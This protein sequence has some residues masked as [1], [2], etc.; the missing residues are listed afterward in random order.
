MS[1]VSGST[2]GLRAIKSQ[3]PGHLGRVGHGL[4]FMAWASSSTRIWLVTP[5]SSAPPLSQHLLQTEQIVCQFCGCVDVQ[6]SFL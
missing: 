1:T 6:A 3:V 2:L 4:S 5:A